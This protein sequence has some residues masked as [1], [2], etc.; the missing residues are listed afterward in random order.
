MLSGSREA[1]YNNYQTWEKKYLINH[2]HK[3]EPYFYCYIWSWQKKQYY[4]D[5]WS[6][7]TTIIRQGSNAY[8]SQIWRDKTVS[9]IYKSK[10]YNM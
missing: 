4:L 5:Q 2:K 8:D 7:I 3:R 1:K 6:Q 9:R 10:I